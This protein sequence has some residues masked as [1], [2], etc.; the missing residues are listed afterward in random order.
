MKILVTGA[1]GFIGFFTA[2]VLLERGDD[3]VGLDNFNDYYDPALK[4]SRADLLAKH[5][6][7]ELVRLDLADRAGLEGLFAAHD[8]E[9]VVNLAAQAGV[10]Y[11]IENP[12]AY[13]DANIVG[14][15]NLLESCRHNNIKHL[16]F[17]SS[18][19]VYGANTSMPF[20]GKVISN[21]P[22]VRSIISFLYASSVLL[23]R[24]EGPSKTNPMLVAN[25]EG[26]A[27]RRKRKAADKIKKIFK[28]ITCINFSPLGMKKPN[29]TLHQRFQKQCSGGLIYLYI[30][31]IA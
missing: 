24:F 3:V 25:A 28:V 22:S 11:S 20:S 4:E 27:G 9:V 16:V 17:A 29:Y 8:F 6:R 30:T 1:A 21:S 13:V 26:A 14:F 7:F 10:R 18:S 2:K 23:F 19:S 31:A 12:H 15:V 5:D